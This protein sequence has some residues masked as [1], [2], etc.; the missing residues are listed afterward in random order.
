[1]ALNFNIICTVVDFKRAIIITFPTD[2][3]VLLVV[4]RCSRLLRCLRYS[5]QY[6]TIQ[7]REHF[8]RLSRV[9]NQENTFLQCQIRLKFR[10]A[11]TRMNTQTG[12]SKYFAWSFRSMPSSV[13]SDFCLS[14]DCITYKSLFKPKLICNRGWDKSILIT[15]T[16]PKKCNNN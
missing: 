8:Y 7:Y 6:N 14:V 11:N 9:S 5:V 12:S 10:F 3:V 16:I 4:R 2:C 13:L 15:V 1:M